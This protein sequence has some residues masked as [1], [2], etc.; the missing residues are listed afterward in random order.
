MKN[1]S[2][3]KKIKKLAVKASFFVFLMSYILYKVEKIYK[4]VPNSCLNQ[5][6]ASKK[7]HFMGLSEQMVVPARIELATHG[8]SVRCSTY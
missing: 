3:L 1:R 5:L 8:F 7:P 4:F 2:G 6:K